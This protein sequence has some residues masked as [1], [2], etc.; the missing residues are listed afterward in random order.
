M[1]K[2]NLLQVIFFPSLIFFFLSCQKTSSTLSDSLKASHGDMTEDMT[3]TK[4]KLSTSNKY[5]KPLDSLRN[6]IEINAITTATVYNCGSNLSANYYGTGY[7]KY[8]DYSLNLSSTPQGATIKITVNS[9][10]IPNKFTVK[11]VN[12]TVM[13]STSWMGYVNYSGPWGLSL[14]TPQTNTLTFLKDV[15]SS[16][17]LIVETLTNNYSDS[18]NASISCTPPALTVVNPG[19]AG[20]FHNNIIAAIDNSFTI[21]GINPQTLLAADNYSKS[22]EKTYVSNSK[23]DLP[24]ATI[25]SSYGFRN[26]LFNI[27]YAS[28][29]IYAS[30]INFRR[31]GDSMMNLPNTSVL[32]TSNEKVMMQN[33]LIYFEQYQN[34]Q[35]N[36]TTMRS[37][38]ASLKNTWNQQGFNT[39]LH[40]GDI[41]NYTLNIA[42][43]SVAFWYRYNSG[44]TFVSGRGQS[45]LAVPVFL[46]AD[47]V[48]AL[49][50]SI[51]AGIDSYANTGKVNWKSVGAWALGGA[52]SS[53]IPSTRWFTRFFK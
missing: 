39:S 40:Q 7:Y 46:A 24:A 1:Q 18:W 23:I 42:D 16:F 53:S 31:I 29:S 4:W 20:I 2:I 35:I 21:N 10:D 15:T 38:I 17:T 27:S 22:Y 43:S 45:I 3:L 30:T 34:G 26:K 11:D 36:Y 12:G 28:N 19:N 5:E 32:I 44:S 9:Y 41:S 52:I 47:A 48:G 37:Q 13:A 6:Q 50:G 14:N 51:A 49:A 8:P 25:D 33:L